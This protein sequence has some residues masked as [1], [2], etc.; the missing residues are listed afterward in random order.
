MAS[1]ENLL[2]HAQEIKSILAN[3]SKQGPCD[4]LSNSSLKVIEMQGHCHWLQMTKMNC[5]HYKI[6]CHRN[7]NLDN[8]DL[9]NYTGVS[10]QSGVCESALNQGPIRIKKYQNIK[11]EITAITET[12]TSP[13]T[14]GLYCG[15]FDILF[16]GLVCFVRPLEI[17]EF[18]L[19]FVMCLSGLGLLTVIYFNSMI[20]GCQVMN[21]VQV[22]LT[23]QVLATRVNQIPERDEEEIDISE[24]GEDED[25]VNSDVDLD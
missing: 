13:L 14:I 10:Y 21:L 12:E 15:F 7:I 18:S 16:G 6:H 8:V 1:E 17:P 3:F 23:S 20:R 4:N 5:P 24:H 2:E 22:I 25:V 11:N 19:N 9:Y